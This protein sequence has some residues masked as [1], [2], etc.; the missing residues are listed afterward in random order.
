MDINVMDI[1]KFFVLVIIIMI[2][3][4]LIKGATKN[5]KNETAR[6]VLDNT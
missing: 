4:Y 3:M 6:K 2:T 5:V 1:A